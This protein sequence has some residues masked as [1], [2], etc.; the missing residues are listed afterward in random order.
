MHIFKNSS[1]RNKLQ[2]SIIVTSGIVLLLASAAFVTNDLLNFRRNMVADLFILANLIGINSTA[3]L[4]FKDNLTT[5]ENIAA[6]KAHSHITLTYIFSKDGKL[7]ASYY[8]NKLEKPKYSTLSEYYFQYIHKKEKN[9]IKDNHFFSQDHLN[10]F[11]QIIFKDKVIGTVYIQSDLDAFNQRLLLVVNIMGIVM[12]F[13]LILAFLL[14]FRFQRIITAPIYQLL[15]TMKSVSTYQNYSLRGEKITHDE[16]G[17]LI[18]GFNE[19]LEQ[20]EKRDTELAEARDQAMM[21]NRAKSIFLANMSHEIRTPLNGILGYAQILERDKNLNAD[22]KKGIDII[23]H[24]GEYLLNL[25]NDI[26]DL[27]KIEAGKLELS[28]TEFHLKNFLNSLAELFLMRATQQEITFNY[29]FSKRLPIGIY[30]DEIRLRQILINL[31]GNAVKFTRYGTVSFRVD[32]YNNK[33]YFKIADT[34]IGIADDE[35]ETIFLPFKQAGEQNYRAQG[36]GLGLSITKKLIKMMGGELQVESV[37]GKGSTFSMALDLPVTSHLAEIESV[38]KQMIVGYKNLPDNPRLKILV[39]DDNDENRKIIKQ[40]LE[41]LKFNIV[42]AINGKEG[43]DKTRELCPDLIIMDLIMPEMDGFE[44]TRETRKIP[45]FQKVPIIA[46]SA[47]VFEYHRQESLKSGCDD[48]IAKP[49]YNNELLE[50]ISKYLHLEAIYEETFESVVTKNEEKTGLPKLPAE[51]AEI[52][53]NLAM[54]G[55]IQGI[56]EF[57]NQLKQLDKQLM[58]VAIKIYELANQFENEKLC[59]LAQNSISKL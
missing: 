18:D 27:S 3:G 41:P 19:M 29:D 51:Q 12:L 4:I 39:I 46:A 59:E 53:L 9:K 38:E 45:K 20:I 47:S 36:T 54:I 56:L 30:G 32:Y 24:S 37:L 22:H 58:P 1:L 11:K 52:L 6:L 50:I 42:E 13:S 23:K 40:L 7:F 57:A 21:A 55:D 14:A 17:K 5:E 48:F 15:D 44:S 16:L 35:L 31:L 26:L 49:I 25:I 8:K 34:G 10:I 33:L 43:L 2:A 28:Q